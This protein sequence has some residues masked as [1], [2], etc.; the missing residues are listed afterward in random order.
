MNSKIE[1]YRNQATGEVDSIE[2]GTRIAQNEPMVNHVFNR[3]V[4]KLLNNDLEIQK[5]YKQVFGQ[6]NIVDYSPNNVYNGDDLVW[7][8]DL[9]KNLYLLKCITPNNRIPPNTTGT[10]KDLKNSG[11]EN[12]NKYL[13]ILD[14]GIEQFLRSQ[15]AAIINEHQDD[16]EM[17]PFGAVSLDESSPDYIGN[18]LLK[19]DF[20]NINKQ[21][22]TTF[23]PMQVMKLDV[24]DVIVHGYSRQ[25]GKVLEY[26]IV[27]KL[28]TAAKTDM[29]QIFENTTELSA[30]TLVLPLYSSYSKTSVSY[31]ENANYF[32]SATDMD[33][34]SNGE[35]KDVGK[36]SK[37]LLVQINRNDYV[38]TYS[39]NIVF[40][41][42]FIDRKYMVFS[43]SVLSQTN[44]N[45]G[46]CACN[47]PV[48][49]PSANDITFCNKTRQSITAIDITFPDS[50]QYLNNGHNTVYNG[51]IANS[52]HCKIIGITGV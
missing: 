25:Y 17:H 35:L 38:N 40:P 16:I 41:I 44:G 14:Y 15:D 32:K 39:A 46:E 20:S 28:A 13:N 23:F 33:I 9:D 29:T 52:F 19:N 8:Q 21:R 43:N 49:V 18:K 47:S 3:G 7:Y 27:F 4:L 24:G 22:K 34:F 30:N 1:I 2:V 36:T 31:Q 48:I 50:S 5:L 12:Q 11:W 37:G 51:L 6:L 26:D 45:D 10:D 42:P